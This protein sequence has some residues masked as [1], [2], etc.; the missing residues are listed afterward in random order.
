MG[1]PAMSVVVRVNKEEIDSA[2]LEAAVRRYIVQLEEDEDNEFEMTDANIKYLKT[3]VLNQIIE[4]RLMV[5]KARQSGIEVSDEE[6]RSRI[7]AMRA[8]FEDESEWEANLLAL[9]STPEKIFNEV[10]EDIQLEQ[11]IE[12]IIGNRIHFSDDDLQKYFEEHETQMKEPDLYSFYEVYVSNTEGVNEAAFILN[13]ERN[14]SDLKKDFAARSMQFEQ[15][16]DVPASRLPEEIYNVLSDLEPGKIGTMLA[17]ES[18]LIVYQLKNRIIGKKFDFKEIKGRLRSY[19][20]SQG[21]KEILS[22]VVNQ[23]LDE[24]D[25]EYMDISSI[26]G[27]GKKSP[28]KQ[29]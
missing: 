13:S 6:V 2:V 26:S 16:T 8:Q 25:I 27:S 28:K 1:R 19:L 5:Q 15:Y 9:G 12:Q 3:E 24:A 18:Q 20:I 17:G 11:Y 7:L 4:R 23:A 14:I 29:G 21:R 22:Q 10:Q